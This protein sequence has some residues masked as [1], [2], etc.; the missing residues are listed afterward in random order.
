VVS[1]VEGHLNL[2]VDVQKHNM[3]VYDDDPLTLAL[4]ASLYGEASMPRSVSVEQAALAY[5][6]CRRKDDVS[7]LL[8]AILENVCEFPRET[9]F[10]KLR[11]SNK[12]VARVWS[13]AAAR[14][15]LESVGWR[16]S[17]NGFAEL[18]DNED[19]TLS[20]LANDTLHKE[21]QKETQK[22]CRVCNRAVAAYPLPPGGSFFRRARAPWEAVVCTICSDYVVCGQCFN[23]GL[24]HDPDHAL[25]PMGYEQ[26]RPMM[27]NVGF[28]GRGHA[29]PR[30]SP[31]SYRDPSHGRR[32]PWG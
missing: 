14:T 31:P 20:C 22:Y 9:K 8:L 15:L 2:C 21:E 25:A 17:E 28:G 10:R 11:L 6:A 30:R 5:V 26:G 29:P 7:K 27:S 23:D 12:S 16:D 3:T 4:R 32:G 19:G 18:N 1:F 24:Q 13:Q